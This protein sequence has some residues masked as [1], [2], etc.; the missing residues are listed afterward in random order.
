MTGLA[1]K[2]CGSTTRKVERP[3]P[4]CVTCRRARRKTTKAS[5]HENYV[6]KTYGLKPGQYAEIL[7]AQWGTCYLC[8]RATGA[9]KKL[10]VDHDHTCCPETPTC[11]KCTRGLLCGPCNKILGHARDDIE[12]FIRA[13]MYLEFPPARRVIG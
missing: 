4:R 8:E 2:D 5:T 12:F 11:G 13:R 1:C 9:T 7:A 3:G 10:A 6:G